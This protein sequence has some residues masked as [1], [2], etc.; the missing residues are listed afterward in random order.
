MC[1]SAAYLTFGTHSLLALYQV[2]ETEHYCCVYDFLDWRGVPRDGPMNIQD[3]KISPMTGAHN[4]DGPTAAVPIPLNRHPRAEQPGD[5]LDR[6]RPSDTPAARRR[7]P[8]RLLA[9]TLRIF[10]KIALPLAVVAG[11]YAA[12]KALVASRPAAP[13][14]PKSERAFTV[15][16][17]VVTRGDFQPS[18]EIFGTAVAGRQVDIRSLV[19]GQVIETGPNLREAGIVETG[20]LLV[21]IDPIDYATAI[22]EL[23]AQLSETLARKSEFESSLAAARQSLEYAREQ[24]ELAKADL[25]RAEPLARRGAVSE[26]TVDDRRQILLQ[27]RQ[28]ADELDNNLKVWQARIDQQAAAAER[29]RTSI[30]RARR[31]LEE[32]ELKAPFSAYVTEVGAQVGR[33]VGQNDKVATLIDRDW[34]EVRFTL[35]D[36]QYGRIVAKEGGIDGRPIEVRWVLGGNT[37]EYAGR[38][39][40]VGARIAS[41]TGGIEVYARI[42]DP[43][44]PVPLRPGAFVEISVP[45]KTYESAF[46]V[47]ATALY[48]GDTVYAIVE[49]RLEAR[50]VR[51]AGGI[52]EDLLVEGRLNDG[53]RVL[54]S[55]ISTPGDGV[56]VNEAEQNP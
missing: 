25:E 50:K 43:L 52:A 37:F 13:V 47:P 14:Q 9:A 51:V 6:S 8:L 21:K 27:R 46:R 23:E 44:R 28:A 26:R 12:Y 35:T 36:E 53:D 39:E 55:R 1:A 54:T 29:I 10:L 38:I 48:D 22:D 20:D 4:K 49:G 5:P 16:S 33:I 17:A 40:H 11:G 30:V 42:T 41:D 2:S 3:G 56:K 15:T 24:L 18:L 31:R 19:S 32:T 45:D 34:I 7:S